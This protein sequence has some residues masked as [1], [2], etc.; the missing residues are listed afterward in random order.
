MLES[1]KNVLND[2]V[3]GLAPEKTTALTL[4][5]DNKKVL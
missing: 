2:N 1:V 5:S 3:W 4:G